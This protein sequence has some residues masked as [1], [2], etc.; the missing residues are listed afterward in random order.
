[1]D[2]P[3]SRKRIVTLIIMDILIVA[4]LTYAFA[5]CFTTS[6]D[7]SE[8]FLASYVPLF[9]PTIVISFFVLRRIKRQEAALLPDAEASGA[10][11]E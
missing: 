10:V 6:N 3:L 5:R 2:L 4:E 11:V 1:M 7:F 8:T 9:V